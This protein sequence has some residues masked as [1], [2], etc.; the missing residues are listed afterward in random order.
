MLSLTLTSAYGGANN[1]ANERPTT[2]DEEFLWILLASY[3]FDNY[4]ESEDWVVSGNKEGMGDTNSE[5][6]IHMISGDAE[7]MWHLSTRLSSLD[8]LH[9]IQ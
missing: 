5:Y 9:W 6:K 1:W 3:Y 2:F 7:L 4:D 8:T